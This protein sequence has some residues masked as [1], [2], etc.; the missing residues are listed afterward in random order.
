VTGTT[1]IYAVRAINRHLL[2]TLH[3]ILYTCGTKYTCGALLCDMNG[4]S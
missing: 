3:K 4:A 2:I 1:K